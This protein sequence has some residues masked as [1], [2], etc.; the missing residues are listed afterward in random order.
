MSGDAATIAVDI[1][2]HDIYDDLELLIKLGVY[3]AF[4]RRAMDH[5]SHQ[6]ILVGSTNPPS[7]GLPDECHSRIKDQGSRIKDQCRHTPSLVFI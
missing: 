4:L 3:F 5:G 7:S 6:S 2:G 1:W